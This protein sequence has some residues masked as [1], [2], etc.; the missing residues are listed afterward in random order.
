MKCCSNIDSQHLPG[1]GFIFPF[2][3]PS[4]Y[5]IQGYNTPCPSVTDAAKIYFMSASHHLLQ[6]FIRST[7]FPLKKLLKIDKGWN[8]S[9]LIYVVNVRSIK[10]IVYL[11]FC[12][13]ITYTQQCVMICKCSVFPCVNLK[14]E[15][16]NCLQHLQPV[17]VWRAFC[18]VFTYKF[19]L[20]SKSSTYGTFWW[21]I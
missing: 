4:L 7:T 15:C 19:L 6:S 2:W 1:W 21:K 14:N 9:Q 5:C 16:F 20:L 8:Y 12:C 10:E 17:F 18:D 3:F 11:P 13:M